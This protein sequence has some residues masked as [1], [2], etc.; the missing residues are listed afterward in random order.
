MTM[1]SHTKHSALNWY[2]YE[3][4]LRF[5]MV[6]SLHDKDNNCALSF[7][8]QNNKLYVSSSKVLS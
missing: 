4:Y 6:V 2:A 1:R 7:H 5:Q 3:S 8:K